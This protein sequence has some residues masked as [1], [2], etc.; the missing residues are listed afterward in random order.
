MAKKNRNKAGMLSTNAT[1]ADNRRARFDYH[2]EEKFEAGIELTGTEV[3][4]LRLG[5]C[6]LNESYVGPKGVDIML[7]NA[8]IP[9][10]QQAGRHLQHEPKRP[11]KLLLRKCEIDKLLGSV[12]R[13]G[14][15]IVPTRLY[16]NARGLAKLEI[17]LAKGKKEHDKRETIKQR[18]WGRQKQ[19]LLKDLG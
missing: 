17:A 14:Y 15:T 12:T 9:E 11:R 1:V 7:F 13:E 18:E 2:L 8:F 6:S 3:K 19:K 4:S 16:F 10:Y 5:Q